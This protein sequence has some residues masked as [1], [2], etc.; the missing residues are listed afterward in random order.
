MVDNRLYIS[1]YIFPSFV[2]I[3][4]TVVQNTTFVLILS[5]RSVS[6]DCLVMLLWRGRR[7]TID[8]LY[9]R[10]VSPFTCGCYHFNFLA[11]GLVK[12]DLE[13][14]PCLLVS[15]MMAPLPDVFVEYCYL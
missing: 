15:G 11:V 9:R 4:A 14:C 8:V 3:G 7:Y 2:V 10:G 1:E 13:F 6:G 5:S 12:E